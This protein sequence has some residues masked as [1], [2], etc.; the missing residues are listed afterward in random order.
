MRQKNVEHALGSASTAFYGIG[1]L[2]AIRWRAS[3]TAIVSACRALSCFLAASATCAQLVTDGPLC[4][5]WR[6]RCDRTLPPRNANDVCWFCFCC[7]DERTAPL[8]LLYAHRKELRD[9]A[10]KDRRASGLDR[11]NGRH[12]STMTSSSTSRHTQSFHTGG[13][14]NGKASPLLSSFRN[15]LQS[16]KSRRAGGPSASFSSGDDDDDDDDEEPISMDMLEAYRRTQMVEQQHQPLPR[17]TIMSS[18]TVTDSGNTTSNKSKNNVLG[19]DNSMIISA[20]HP[21]YFHHEDRGGVAQPAP[22]L[23]Q[24]STHPSFSR[25]LV[26]GPGSTS[27][28][29]R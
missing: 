29:M 3:R 5:C 15:S 1:L 16:I 25:V 8:S 13:N 22:H 27:Y 28:V 20:T 10:R 14:D 7:D 11:I 6:W 4:R 19:R 21:Q 23:P 9:D 18:T 12:S 24:P 2:S 26:I 17:H